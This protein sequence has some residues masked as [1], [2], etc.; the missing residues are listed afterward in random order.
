MSTF[1]EILKYFLTL[2]ATGFGGPLAL[3]AIMQKDLVDDRKWIEHNEFLQVLA[4][5]KAMPGALAFQTAVYLGRHRGGR[6]GGLAAGLGLLLPS[7]FIMVFL[8]QFYFLAEKV[9]AMRTFFNGMQAAA[10]VIMIQ[11][12]RS[13]GLPYFKISKFWLAF[14]VGGSIFYLDIISEPILIL[15][16]GILGIAWGLRHRLNVIALFPL[17]GLPAVSLSQLGELLWVCFKSGAVVFGSGIAIVPLLEK[18]FVERLGWITSQ[19]F[20]DALAL[21]QVTPGPVLMTVTFIGFRVAGWS[22]AIIATVAVF[23]ASFFHMQTWFPSMVGVLRRQKWINDFLIPSIGVICGVLLVTIIKIT[24]AWNTES[25][26]LMFVA[27][28]CALVAVTMKWPS[29]MLILTG[30]ILALL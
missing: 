7:F 17:E 19:E 29:W 16:A 28:L 22:G 20:L 30:G 14:A 12:L 24:W 27:F 4:L 21:G 2:G 10:I 15:A 25:L 3:V 5:L 8:A 26:K 6:W 11:G 9:V 1:F 13:L 18:D 23:A